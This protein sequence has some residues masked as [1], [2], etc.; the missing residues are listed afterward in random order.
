LVDL[1]IE[2]GPYGVFP[3]ISG[4]TGSGDGPAGGCRPARRLLG[5]CSL[6]GWT[7]AP[8]V[9]SFAF[10]GLGFL[11]CST[12]IPFIQICTR[13]APKASQQKGKGSAAGKGAAPSTLPK[14]SWEGSWVKDKEIG[15]ECFHP[16]IS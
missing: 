6:E 15:A 9:P 14:G 16:W 2:V 3:A 7:E 5:T 4:R 8:L 10:K 12:A 1:V 11:V 13:M